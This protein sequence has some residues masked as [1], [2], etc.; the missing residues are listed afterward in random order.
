MTKACLPQDAQAIFTLITSMIKEPV[1]YRCNN[2]KEL[3][4]TAEEL[5]Q[6]C[7]NQRT[8]TTS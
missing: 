8:T 5:N 2:C 6:H 3:F 7:D 4:K 1:G